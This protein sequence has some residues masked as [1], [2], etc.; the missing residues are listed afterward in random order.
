M[1]SPCGPWANRTMNLMQ[2]LGWSMLQVKVDRENTWYVPGF[3]WPKPSRHPVGAHGDVVAVDDPHAHLVLRVDARGGRVPRGTARRCR[4]AQ[5]APWWSAPRWAAAASVGVS[6]M[7]LPRVAGDG[8][9]AAAT[10]LAIGHVDRAAV[11]GDGGGRRVG[12]RRRRRRR[13]RHR[14]HAQRCDAHE[15][16]YNPNPRLH[17]EQAS[18]RPSTSVEGANRTSVDQR[19]AL[20]QAES[21]MPPAS[22]RSAA[23]RLD[24]R[25]RGSADRRRST[26]RPSPAG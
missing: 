7:L 17:V 21:V 19:G 9:S 12:R 14:A 1:L 24:G 3:G 5:P 6:W 23:A 8:A 20:R 11:A 2:M 18:G 22:A 26:R 4:V 16:R 15:Q 10:L 13:A 25:E